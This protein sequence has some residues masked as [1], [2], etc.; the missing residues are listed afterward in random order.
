MLGWCGGPGADWE[1]ICRRNRDGGVGIF[2]P[3][4][5]SAANSASTESGSGNSVV[6]AEARP[7]TVIP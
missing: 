2:M 4:Q 5:L 6:S 1:A 7:V 3:Y